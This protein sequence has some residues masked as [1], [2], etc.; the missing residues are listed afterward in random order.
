MMRYDF[1]AGASVI[2]IER[3]DAMTFIPN[4]LTFVRSALRRAGPACLARGYSQGEQP[5]CREFVW[6]ELLGS[7][8]LRVSV[9]DFLKR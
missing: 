3:H 1:A 9:R 5:A 2:E 4:L 7:V 8:H 6:V